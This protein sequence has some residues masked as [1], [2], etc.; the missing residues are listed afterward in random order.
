MPVATM[1]CG[2]MVRSETPSV[3]LRDLLAT[4]PHEVPGLSVTR[5]GLEDVYLQLV[6]A[7]TE[8]DLP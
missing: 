4:T 6:S 8:G 7:N 3:V 1:R 5:P 2:A